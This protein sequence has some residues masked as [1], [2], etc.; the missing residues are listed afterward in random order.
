MQYRL[1]DVP[2]HPLEPPSL[3]APAGSGTTNQSHPRRQ[4]AA[5]Y[6]VIDAD[7]DEPGGLG[8]YWRVV[9]RHR[10]TMLLFSAVGT[11]VAVLITVPQTPV[12][13]AR[14]SLEVENVNENFLNMRDLS[15]TAPRL[16]VDYDIQTQA[17][18]LQS[19][20]LLERTIANHSGLAQRLTD[21]QQASRTFLW[22]KTFGLVAG[23][24]ATPS[25]EELVVQASG[26]LK[27]RALPNTRIIEVSFDATDRLLA[28]DFANA[29]A[30]E[31]IEL[32]LEQRWRTNQH[33]SEWLAK[34]MQDL[35]I[36]L[37][38]SEEE[39]Q[40]YARTS[41]LIF[42]SEKNNLA[43]E[44][45]RQLQDELLKA[46][47][48]GVA[49]R[50]KY[51]LATTAPLDTLP[52]VL[53][54]ATLKEYQVELT[55]LR[56]Q[57]AE[58]LSSYT[59]A[60][61]K[62]IKLQAQIAT[63]QA[64]LDKKRS[65][66]VARVRNEY[67]TAR[68]RE[69]L[70]VADYGSQVQLVSGQADKVTH[71]NT[72]KREVDTTRQLY[73]SMFQRVK[74]AGLASALR[75]SNIHVVDPALPP[76]DPYKP[77]VL[78]N[79][80]FGLLSGMFL[81]TTLAVARERSDRRIQEPGDASQYL[82]VSELGIIPAEE[83]DR[84]RTRRG[85]RSLV[86]QASERVELTTW[87]RGFSIMGEAFRAAVT[88]I[89]FSE[90]N[91]GHASVLV[92]SS[93][94]A[95][96]GKTTVSSNLGI[97]LAQANQRVLL[98]DGDLRRPRLDQIFEVENTVGLSGILSGKAM[99]TLQETKIPKLF[100]LPSG[101][102]KDANILFA[103][104]L[105]ELL[106]RLRTEFDII[107]IDSPP[108]LQVPDARILAR[109]ADGVVLIIRARQTTRDAARLACEQLELDGSAVLGTILNDWKPTKGPG[110]DGYGAYAHQAYGYSDSLSGD[111]AS[112]PHENP[113]A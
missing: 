21:S 69:S 20:A 32:T 93:A 102:E 97:A 80:S 10:S 105:R 31:F 68:R 75:A 16:G 108:L 51:E 66:I 63:V 48:D 94:S 55:T 67:E 90:P 79:A 106:R 113:A 52:E 98:I 12:Y 40:K 19:R 104:M 81:G 45:L 73:E 49:K 1:L 4:G 38:K 96:E 100:L 62:V 54:D 13:Q 78:L 76:R 101:G 11:I 35:K 71:Y 18:I 37:E 29:I 36:K 34:Q 59:Q 6:R 89:L 3:E 23:S 28:A 33:T 74:E 86:S 111:A 24:T 72:L 84:R 30:S 8:Q 39:L 65:N 70:L 92:I 109:H 25:R 15:P 58:L 77:R 2:E 27:V 46:Q 99:L 87:Q 47:A 42:T 88:S 5:A 7:D 61:P 110:S 95:G 56:R 53:D 85:R 9:V 112:P 64:A 22:R 41:N 83:V 103:P 91:R 43:E 26:Q 57:L 44:R 14:M 82:N 50:S 17:K 107:L 60:H